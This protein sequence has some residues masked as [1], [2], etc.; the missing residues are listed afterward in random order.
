MT[1]HDLSVRP[2]TPGDA[3]AIRDLVLAAYAKWVPLIGREPRP[4]SA[5]YDASVREHEFDLVL[6]GER[7]V[8]LIEMVLR[9][10]HLWIENVAV[11]PSAQGRGIGRQ[12][13]ARAEDRAR[14]A[15]RTETRLLTNGAF[16]A[17]ISLYERVGYVVTHTEPYLGG[18][19]VY[20]TKQL[21]PP[22]TA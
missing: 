22:V 13:L 7:L 2:A 1:D 18:V 20:M 12:L 11:S 9:D 8:G 15:G 5:D 10:D 19:T 4:M 6:E 21:A 14:R 16:A 3:A 17:N